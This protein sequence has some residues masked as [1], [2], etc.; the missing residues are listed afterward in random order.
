ME[1]DLKSFLSISS[2]ASD[3]FMCSSL[4]LWDGNI[5]MRDNMLNKLSLNKLSLSVIS[6]LHLH[7]AKA[8]HSQAQAVL[9]CN[10]NY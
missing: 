5:Q 4:K 2:S 8:K 7:K 1:K 3:V 6:V 10:T 9:Y